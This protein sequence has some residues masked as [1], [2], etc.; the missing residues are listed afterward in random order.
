MLTNLG[1]N[2]LKVLSALSKG[3]K[4]GLE[5]IKFLRDIGKHESSIGGLYTTLHRLENKGYIKGRYSN[6]SDVRGGN[7]RKYYKF[8]KKGEK[9]FAEV[10]KLFLTLLK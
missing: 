6:K 8:T 3:E 7:R 5:I 2:E 10:R 4:Y 9:V 1:I